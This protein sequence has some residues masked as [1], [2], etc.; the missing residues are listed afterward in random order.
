M[1]YK[2][3]EFLKDEISYI[4]K[5]R[6]FNSSYEFDSCTAARLKVYEVEINNI[7]IH[8]CT[9]E[10]SRFTYVYLSNGVGIY[11]NKVKN[12]KFLDNHISNMS[13]NQNSVEKSF[14]KSFVISGNDVNANDINKNQ[15]SEI[16]ADDI[17]L[18]SLRFENNQYNEMELSSLLLGYAVC[19]SNCY[20]DVVIEKARVKKC[21][22]VGEKIENLRCSD[23]KFQECCFTGIDFREAAF[24][25]CTFEDCQFMDC[26]YTAEQKELFGLE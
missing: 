12:C 10:E 16:K 5:S 13:I 4:N 6:E 1:N 11:E 9:A 23:A 22:F 17:S 14:I 7:S 3:R 18:Q 25:N 15:F 2:N 21:K 26:M 19:E 8:K 20:K 24:E